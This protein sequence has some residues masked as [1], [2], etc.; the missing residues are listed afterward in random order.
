[1]RTPY[2][3]LVLRVRPASLVVA[4]AALAL[5]GVFVP[6]PVHALEP[7]PE[8]TSGRLLPLNPSGHPSAIGLRSITPDYL[9]Y[10][11]PGLA[12]PYL[13]ESFSVRRVADGSL[14]TTLSNQMPT[15]NQPLVSGN[16]VVQVTDSINGT[17]ATRSTSHG[18]TFGGGPR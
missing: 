16:S 9:V 10:T 5:G 15:R 4:V 11:D 8:V 14:V 1:M 6:A 13:G 3:R 2:L 17:P 12:N 7:G 18:G